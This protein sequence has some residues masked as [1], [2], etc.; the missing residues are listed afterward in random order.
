[1][2]EEFIEISED[3]VK[4]LKTFGEVMDNIPKMFSTCFGTK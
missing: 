2:Q 4:F 3:C 1:M